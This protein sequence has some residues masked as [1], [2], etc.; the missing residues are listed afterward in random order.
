MSDIRPPTR[1]E[2]SAY[3]DGELDAARQAEIARYLS[4][5]ADHDALLSADAA[6]LGG[7]RNLRERLSPATTP[8][9]LRNAARR[10]RRLHQLSGRRVLLIGAGL[11]AAAFAGFAITPLIRSEPSG[12]TSVERSIADAAGYFLTDVEDAIEFGVSSEAPILSVLPSL[13]DSALRAR[14]MAGSG[15]V[16]LGGRTSSVSG[17]GAVILFYRDHSG[18]RYGLTIWET[19]E[20]APPSSAFTAGADETLFWAEGGHRYAVTGDRDRV[21]LEAF[22]AAYRERVAKT[23]N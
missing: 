19:A 5:R 14:I 22:Q 17:A 2:L 3:T 1:E 4:Q 7:L 15:F 11:V 20:P 21:F 18:A 12:R 10:G 6:I 13:S 16:Y 9:R 8:K 23:R